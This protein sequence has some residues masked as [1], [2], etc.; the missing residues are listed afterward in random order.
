MAEVDDGYDGYYAERLWQLLP[1]VYRALDSDDPTITGPLQELVAR[2][3]AQ[4]SVVRRSVDRL[5]ADQSIETCDDWV[6]PYIGDLL[7]ANLVSGDARGQ[8]LEVAKTIHYRRRKGTLAVLEEIARDVTG[9]EAHVVEAFRRLARTRHNLDPPVGRE[10]LV[11]ALPVPCPGSAAAGQAD[12]GML[13]ERERLSGPLTGTLAGGLRRPALCARRAASGCSVRR[14]FPHRRPADRAGRGRTVWDPQTDGVRVAAAELCRRS[15]HAGARGR[16]RHPLR[17]RSDRPE[18][19][20]VLTAASARAR[21][22]GGHLDVHSRMAGSRAADR[23]AC[24]CDRRP[25]NRATAAPAVSRRGR[26]ARVLRGCRRRIG[27]APRDPGFGPSWARSA[28]SRR[29]RTRRQSSTST[30]SPQRSEP[31]PT[32]AR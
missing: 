12:P 4:V 25:G 30:A 21:R 1:G 32:T 9:W 11:A 7:D 2:I 26:D 10:S 3:G 29:S 6:I 16:L 8:R 15:R 22:L 31:V 14:V 23:L 18:R 5:W 19:A 27:R 13:L 17:V 20:A 24:G 28:S